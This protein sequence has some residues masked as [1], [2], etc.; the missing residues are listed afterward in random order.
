[1]EWQT[2]LRPSVLPSA[3]AH[4]HDTSQLSAVWN[5]SSVV[6]ESVSGWSH[7]FNRDV[8]NVL[9]DDDDDV[10]AD[11][12]CVYST[13]PDHTPDDDDGCLAEQPVVSYEEV[14]MFVAYVFALVV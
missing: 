14:T 6:H 7:M 13:D 11:N 12:T 1:M 9:D 8:T 2:S 10:N 4:E 3:A 5:S